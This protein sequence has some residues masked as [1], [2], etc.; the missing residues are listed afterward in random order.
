M[1][2]QDAKKRSGLISFR[3]R[4]TVKIIWLLATPV[5]LAHGHTT[6]D[7]GTQTTRKHVQFHQTPILWPEEGGHR[8]AIPAHPKKIAAR[9]G[10]SGIASYYANR[11]HGRRTSSGHLYYKDA[12]TAAHRTLPLGTWVRV[13][14]DTNGKSAVVQITDRGPYAKHR[15][16]DLSRLA[17][18]ELGMIHGGTAPVHLEVVQEYK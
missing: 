4:H 14:N 11:F 6:M 17:A 16:I 8:Q 10:L 12:W 18:N 3:F 5:G 9:K 15:V 7:S 2:R 13:T 1:I